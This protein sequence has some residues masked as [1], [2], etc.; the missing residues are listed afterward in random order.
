MVSIEEGEEG[1]DYCSSSLEVT[2]L[3]MGSMLCSL[4]SLLLVAPLYKH[5]CIL[6]FRNW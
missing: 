2:L 5:R 4:L 1:G 3:G 6:L